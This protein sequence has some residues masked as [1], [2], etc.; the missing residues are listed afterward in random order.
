MGI[1]NVVKNKIKKRK[2]IGDENHNSVIQRHVEFL[3]QQ[4]NELGS[5]LQTLY[6]KLTDCG[7]MDEI[8]EANE[9]INEILAESER[10]TKRIQ[11][12]KEL[13]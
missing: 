10:L 2:N 3:I 5:R 7:D 9:E 6:A 1:L 12:L 8:L 11:Q 13:G 4:N